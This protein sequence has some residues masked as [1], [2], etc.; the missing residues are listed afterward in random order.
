[1]SNPGAITIST[2]NIVSETGTY[3]FSMITPCSLSASAIF[4]YTLPATYNVTGSCKLNC[5]LV[6]ERQFA[7]TNFLSASVASSSTLTLVFSATNPPTVAPVT[8]TFQLVAYEAGYPAFVATTGLASGQ[9][10]VAGDLGG[11]QLHAGSYTTY[12]TT[13]YVFNFTAT[14]RVPAGSS[15]VFGFPAAVVSAAARLKNAT[16]AGK[17][18]STASSVAGSLNITGAFNTDT[19]SGA[20]VQIA[21]ENVEN[22]AV[23]GAYGTFSAVVQYCGYD[24]DKAQGLSI[25]MTTPAAGT[26]SCVPSNRTNCEVAT[27][28]FSL[29]APDVFTGYTK[30]LTLRRPTAI[31]CNSATISAVSSDMTTSD[32]VDSDPSFRF[33][34]VLPSTSSS[35]SFSIQCTNPKTTQPGT[36]ILTLNAT[37]GTTEQSSILGAVAVSTLNG[38]ALSVS[39]PAANTPTYPGSVTVSLLG[40]AR[41]SYVIP[42]HRLVVTVP[43]VYTP[44][45]TPACGVSVDSGYTCVLVGG[46]LNVTFTTGQYSAGFVISGMKST[47]PLTVAAAAAMSQFAV[48]TY[49][50]VDGEYYM[51]DQTDVAGRLAVSCD[52]P[53]KTCPSSNAT[54]CRSCADY[55]SGVT[56]YFKEDTYECLAGGSDVCGSGYF[57]NATSHTCDRCASNCAECSGSR[58]TCTKCNSTLFL[59]NGNCSDSCGVGF[60]SV[61]GSNV[62]VACKSGCATCSDGNVCKNCSSGYYYLSG[63]CVTDC[64]AG[65]YGNSTTRACESCDPSCSTCK[66]ASTYCTACQGAY[67]KS[68]GCVSES[69]CTADGKYIADK[70]NWNCTNCNSTC[71]TCVT[72]SSHCA[73]CSGTRAFYEEQCVENCPDG[74]YAGGNVCSVCKGY[75]ATC[76][77]AA[78]YCLSCSKGY[79]TS[80]SGE[81]V[82]TC[83]TN[84]YLSGSLCIRC[85]SSCLTCSQSPSSCTGCGPNLY[86]SGNKCVTQCPT[87]AYPEGTICVACSPVCSSCYGS[88]DRCT[89][90]AS[91][92]YISG[93]TCV[94]KC[95]DGSVGV[96]GSC[97]DCNETCAT[98]S[99]TVDTCT[100]CKDSYLYAYGGKCYGTC[101]EHTVASANTTTVRTCIG[102]GT[103]CDACSW[104]PG[105]NSTAAITLYCTVCETGYK[106]LNQSC[107]LVCPDGYST[108]NDGLQCVKT[109]TTDVTTSSAANSLHYAPFPTLIIS[110]GLLC[111]PI[112]GRVANPRSPLISNV[113]VVWSV[114]LFVIYIVQFA[115]AVAEEE[116][117]VLGVTLVAIL[118]NIGLN[119]AFIVFHRRRICR[120]A[121]FARWAVQHPCVN[122]WI[123]IVSPCLSFQLRRLYYCRLAGLDVFFAQFE[124]FQALLLPLNYF[125]LMTIVFS[126]FM[127]L[128]VDIVSLARLSWGTQLYISLIE[129]LIMTSLLIL[130]LAY[131]LRTSKDLS[132][133]L[134]DDTRYSEIDPEK[135]RQRI[136]R[137]VLDEIES[138]NREKI[139]KSL[140]LSMTTGKPPSRVQTEPEA[141]APD[142]AKEEDPRALRSFPCSPRTAQEK[143][144]PEPTF[145]DQGD[146]VYHEE[147]PPV[148]ESVPAEKTD[149]GL[150]TPPLDKIAAFVQHLQ[151]T[152]PRRGSS[153]LFG[154]NPL[155]I[156]EEETK[157]EDYE[158]E[159]PPEPLNGVILTNQQDSPIVPQA[160]APPVTKTVVDM[161]IDPQGKV[162]NVKATTKDS[163]GGSLPPPDSSC[164]SK[165]VANTVVEEGKTRQ[166]LSRT[167]TG[168]RSNRDLMQQRTL[169]DRVKTPDIFESCDGFKFALSR[170]EGGEPDRE[171]TNTA[172]PDLTRKR[173]SV[174]AQEQRKSSKAPEP[175][176]RS[177]T[178]Q[179]ERRLSQP[180]ETLRRESSRLEHESVGDENDSEIL[181]SFDK[182]ECEAIIIRQTEDGRYLDK[183][184]RAVN[185]Y[186][187]LVDR[188]GNILS[189]K[190]NVVLRRD[191]FVHEL[192]L[193]TQ[194]SVVA[195]TA[196][197]VHVPAAS[198]AETGKSDS[199]NVKGKVENQDKQPEVL[200]NKEKPQNSPEQRRSLAEDPL[201]GE[202]PSGYD[203]Q[204]L[205]CPSQD[206]AGGDEKATDSA[207][208]RPGPGDDALEEEAKDVWE[209]DKEPRTRFIRK[210]RLKTAAGN[211]QKRSRVDDTEPR[212]SYMSKSKPRVS[213]MPGKRHDNNRW[214][215]GSTRTMQRT[216]RN[217]PG[218]EQSLGTEG[219]LL[220][221]QE[222]DPVAFPEIN[223]KHRRDSASRGASRNSW[224]DAGSG[225]REHGDGGASGLF[226]NLSKMKGTQPIDRG[227]ES[228]TDMSAQ[229]ES[230]YMA[231]QRRLE[232]TRFPRVDPD[233]A[234][235]AER[236]DGKDQHIFT[237]NRRL[238]ATGT[239]K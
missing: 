227:L 96:S 70:S 215:N 49:T 114:M 110:V 16:V 200:L 68:G 91:G 222:D 187:Y 64:S 1:M 226:R 136:L 102:C 83:G 98:C 104:E 76:S 210:R 2:S 43:S 188:D 154:D 189:R 128:V 55:I 185:Q 125:T 174:L 190:G 8:E 14:H 34:I 236:D 208:L 151:E 141:A 23:T 20:V 176:A 162:A 192:S 22:P 166:A 37:V 183:R 235:S 86:L 238:Y 186:G 24:I 239:F 106:R 57:Q 197:K 111:L 58:T 18:V 85:N 218:A 204:N 148:T 80:D 97:V 87:S 19:I 182:D 169:M 178:V 229:V 170:L 153:K 13:E 65:T 116:A 143:L 207:F 132:A 201:M 181:G 220:G 75:C 155:E 62:C 234:L 133:E 138:K 82:L 195:D 40:I 231:I 5:I 33:K 134:I 15:V 73:T 233:S 149:A 167:G 135:L 145:S 157:K 161:Q 27:Y 90:C 84:Y 120:D 121:G 118:A 163:S 164:E 223:A 184:G 35:L 179:S 93:L 108:S 159:S 25:G 146:N 230:D 216:Q 225:P 66:Y 109:G 54:Q 63:N 152:A 46:K 44:A 56:Y 7:V 237:G 69:V 123:D 209:E 193:A 51:V 130:L 202:S 213:G 31:V 203:V 38:T 11:F 45:S 196:A 139:A 129:S 173:S 6:T 32:I 177:E 89:D 219:N 127:V 39:T 119:V 52:F 42:V 131:E 26:V 4:N 9:G 158:A 60:Y 191:D 160:V 199:V 105:A 101:P 124:D 61:S 198:I 21:L 113:V 137:Q 10:Y 214:M 29:A 71:A 53:C 232:R 126:Y 47:N 3:T 107:Y 12:A 115:C 94:A 144:V 41:T 88:Y 140:G 117:A 59:V 175:Q 92:Y 30:C 67:L 72:T 142:T 74:Y 81:C 150:Q 171:R 172:R 228:E 99:G 221:A 156:I 103:G 79:L 100:S 211:D 112:A 95:P 217:E 147:A 224:L 206:F 78:T 168:V 180:V 28:V 36:F 205:R 48:D 194:E 165:N 122:T 77:G 212:A 17:S 50:L